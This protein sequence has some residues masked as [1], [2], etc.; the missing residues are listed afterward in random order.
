MLRLL[1][2]FVN[3]AYGAL[4]GVAVGHVNV[5]P[6]SGDEVVEFGCIAGGCPVESWIAIHRLGLPALH[7][8][9]D[10]IAKA[11]VRDGELIA[12]WDWIGRSWLD[13]EFV[14]REN[15]IARGAAV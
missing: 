4:E 5:S 6:R 11:L 13:A 9:R 14:R 2:H 15:R 12:V 10:Q 1:R 7:V 8:S 3:G